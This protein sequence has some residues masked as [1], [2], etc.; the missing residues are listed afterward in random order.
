ML[1]VVAPTW[2]SNLLF[3]SILASLSTGDSGGLPGGLGIWASV[4]GLDDSSSL[5]IST[6]RIFLCKIVPNDVLLR[7]SVMAT[8]SVDNPPETIP[9]FLPSMCRPS[10]CPFLLAGDPTSEKH[11]K[12]QLVRHAKLSLGGGEGIKR[13]VFHH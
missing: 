3:S 2:A 12:S 9:T 1:L 4:F 13:K 11:S 5:F 7:L 6:S 8:E 10:S